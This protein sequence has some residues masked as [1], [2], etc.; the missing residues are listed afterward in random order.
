MEFRL[1]STPLGRAPADARG[2]V[3][4][5]AP[6][7]A[8]TASGSALLTAVGA[9]SGYTTEAKVRIRTGH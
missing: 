7:P 5:N 1:G 8:G 2:R 3:S 4:F 9:G 6:V